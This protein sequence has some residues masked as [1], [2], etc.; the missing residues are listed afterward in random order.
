[1]D[2]QMPEMDGFEALRLIRQQQNRTG[3]HVPVIAM[4]AHAMSGDRERCL[5]AGMDDYIAKPISRDE[6]FRVIER[7]AERNLKR[8]P[9]DGDPRQ[10]NDAPPQRVPAA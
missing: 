6:V 3:V 5:S 2:I 7:T 8:A 4:T 1:M 10:E 9:A